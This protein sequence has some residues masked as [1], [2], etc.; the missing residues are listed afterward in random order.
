MNFLE[1]E[2]YV[3]N[4]KINTE[5]IVRQKNHSLNQNQELG[6]KVKGLESIKE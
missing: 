3:N 5:D 2:E 1:K 4:C 6:L